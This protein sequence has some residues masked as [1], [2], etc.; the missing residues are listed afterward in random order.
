MC[1]T[2][3]SPVCATC[4]CPGLGFTG[5]LHLEQKHK[6]RATAKFPDYV[7]KIPIIFKTVEEK[8]VFSLDFNT[9]RGEDLT[10]GLGIPK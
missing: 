4:A 1:A 6:D 10:S 2:W 5:P 7:I 3:L 8:L 9:Q